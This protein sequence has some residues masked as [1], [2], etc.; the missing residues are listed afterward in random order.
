M[1][2]YEHTLSQNTVPLT[3][4]TWRYILVAGVL[5]ALAALVVGR[6]VLLVVGPEGKLILRSQAGYYYEAVP[7]P[8]GLIYD[9]TGHLLAGNREVYELDIRLSDVAPSDIPRMAEEIGSVL[10]LDTDV[11][12]KRLIEAKAKGIPNVMLSKDVSEAQ[13]EVLENRAE[14]W[15]YEN[16]QGE[17]VYPLKAMNFV[18][19]TARFYP[20]G[21]LASNVL[22]FVPPL[23]EH[24]YGGVEQFYDALLRGGVEVR[25]HFYAPWEAEGDRS[26]DAEPV[27]LYLTID[28]NL[29][30]AAEEE[31]AQAVRKTK[32]DFAVI[33]VADPYTG[34]ILA[35]A[36][37]PHPPLGDY[38]QLRRYTEQ[39]DAFNLAIEKPYEPGSVFKVITMAIALDIGSVTPDTVFNDTGIYTVSSARFFNWNRGA[40]GKQ[41][42]VGCLAY[43]LNTCLAWVAH[44]KIPQN[45]FYRYLDAFGFGDLTGIDLGG[46]AP[47][48][49]V[50]PT[51]RDSYGRPLWSPADQASQG[52]G[53]AIMVTPVQ[54]I[55]AISAVANGG[56]LVTPHVLAY[57][58][59]DG[60]RF[61]YH[62]E[63]RGQVLSS[64]TSATLR[65]MLA[66]SLPV[67]TKAALV[68]DYSVAGKTGTAEIAIPGVGYS[69]NLTNASFAGWFPADKPRYVIYVWLSKPK[70]S[71]WASIVAAPVFA[72]MV[73]KVALIEGVP[74][75]KI[76]KRLESVSQVAGKK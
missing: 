46:E 51:S 42:M 68:P 71:P 33:L 60:R 61:A 38:D 72:D 8:R 40:W 5:F 44:E 41:T 13:K 20:E 56:Y 45:T 49:A 25:K 17:K 73:K 4:S 23:A 12:R 30:R 74:P 67:E 53:Q 55:A 10:S 75:D 65:K 76:R 39:W 57:E 52:F 29:Q 7:K 11:L 31:A 48:G 37:S 2:D 35:M 54:M 58:E 16:K 50:T 66:K 70:T 28:R 22:G 24:G 69:T 47:G 9:R 1:N 32:A 21:D 26:L 27:S 36:T 62:P 64:S 43:S 63:G 19:T 15:V 14:A 34:D 3:A 6:M 18:L 59:V